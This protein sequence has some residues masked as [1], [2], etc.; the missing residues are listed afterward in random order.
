M[1][2][3][4]RRGNHR[5][6]SPML[7]RFHSEPAVEAGSTTKPWHSG[8]SSVKTPTD[9]GYPKLAN[10]MGNYPDH[11]IFRRFGWLSTLNIMRLQAELA[12]LEADLKTCQRK[13]EKLQSH[14]EAGETYSTSFEV[15]RGKHPEQLEIME[16]SS[17]V[18][19]EYSKSPPRI[20]I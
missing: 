14:W 15:L 5:N 16:R 19:Q 2:F 1:D 10:L 17:K 8:V 12:Q 7:P 3:E 11:A 9:R 13:D 18:L 4:L 20:N 6:V